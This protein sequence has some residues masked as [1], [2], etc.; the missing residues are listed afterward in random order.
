MKYQL[1]VLCVLLLTLS[2]CTTK[3]ENITQVIGP[4]DWQPPVLSWTALP[5]AEVRGTVGLDVTV[6][7]SSS[8]PV[9]KLY[10]DGA[11]RDSLTSTPYRFSLHTDSLPD[12]VHLCEA[13]AWDHYGNLGISPVLRVNV[14]NS[15]AQGPRLIWVPDSFATND[16]LLEM[17][18]QM[19]QRGEMNK[20][21]LANKA[22][23]RFEAA[24]LV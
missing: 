12:G 9:V 11:L 3:K 22:I 18:V 14:M 1:C 8:I 13:R 2:G 4:T 21:R 5:D 23:S 24:A 17:I 20:L 19:F 7:D 10:V 15:M 6:T 16:R